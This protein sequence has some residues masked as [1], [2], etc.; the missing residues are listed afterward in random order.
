MRR[1]DKIS[2]RGIILAIA[3]LI[4]GGLAWH[5]TPTSAGIEAHSGW[6]NV[7]L[8]ESATPIRG[9]DVDVLFRALAARISDGRIRAVRWDVAP[10]VAESNRLTIVDFGRSGL[11]RIS[12]ATRFTV[13]PLGVGVNT[14]EMQA[15]GAARMGSCSIVGTG[16]GTGLI[17]RVWTKAMDFSQA[18]ALVRLPD[19]AFSPE[20]GNQ[21]SDTGYVYFGARGSGCQ[22]FEAG[23][24]YSVTHHWWTPY[25][26]FDSSFGPSL[27]EGGFLLATQRCNSRLHFCA[28]HGVSKSPGEYILKLGVGVVKVCEDSACTGPERFQSIFIFETYPSELAAQDG[29]AIVARGPIVAQPSWNG[30]GAPCHCRLL[31]ETNIAQPRLNPREQTTF[32]PIFW[33]A[34]SIDYQS[35]TKAVTAGCENWDG[36][37]DLAGL[38]ACDTTTGRI[39][40]GDF[41]YSCEYDTIDPGFRGPTRPKR[42]E[43]CGN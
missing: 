7:A 34:V 42:A 35:W 18:Y 15:S 11:P 24:Q 20:S 31:R 21:Q 27:S 30:W 38:S 19:N 41:G 36:I 29:I 43:Q 8:A 12:S 9:D 4:V 23:F 28:N 39:Q 2:N 17:R 22:N 3:L 32:G 33:A 10:S 5:G 1:Y 40:L 14:A 6:H 16:R 13:R 25:M 26:R 37:S